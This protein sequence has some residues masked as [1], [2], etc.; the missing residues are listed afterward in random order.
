MFN[1][2]SQ[3]HM[4]F[5]LPSR[6]RVYSRT[7]FLFVV[8]LVCTTIGQPDQLHQESTEH[9]PV[10]LVTQLWSHTNPPA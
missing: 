7:F 4:I 2:A 3:V 1:A 5:Y 9:V 6:R 10:L 8:F